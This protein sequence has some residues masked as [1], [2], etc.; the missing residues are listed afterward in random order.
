MSKSQI[1]V[2]VSSA[3][4]FVGLYWGVE[5]KPRKQNKIEKQRVLERESASI[6]VLLK[7]AKS[8]ITKADAIGIKSLEK[9]LEVTEEIH[10]GAVLKKLSGEWYK[11]KF[12][13]IAGFYAQK[14]AEIEKTDVAWSLASTTFAAGISANNKPDNVRQYCLENAVGALEQAITINP[15]NINHRVNL[16]LCYVEM[17]PEENPM[18][19]VMMLLDMNKK[20]PQN[21]TVLFQLGR[22]ALKTGQYEKAVQR[23]EQVLGV[24]VE[25]R[26][27]N[28]LLAS[29]YEN[30]KQAEKALPF[31][32][33]CNK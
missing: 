7:K 6:S 29:I 20:M 11:L 13:E 3:L 33:R 12:P 26:K 10:K 8:T 5:T 32:N 9:E 21:V 22:L 1:I 31:K 19:G 4:L 23:L 28:C 15:D 17:P 30:Q 2:L 27:A 24:D 14:V 25:H 18:K 16:A